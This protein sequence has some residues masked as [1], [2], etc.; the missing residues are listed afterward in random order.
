MVETT[1]MSAT[2]VAAEHATESHAPYLKVWAGLAV[3]TLVEYYY[4]SI[5]KSHFLIL[6]LGLLLLAVVKAGMV[7][8][9]FMH[10]KFEGNW[11]YIAIV[12]AMI[13][14]T[15]IVLALSPDMV[16]KPETEENPGEENARV[17]PAADLPRTILAVRA[18]TSDPGVGARAV[19]RWCLNQTL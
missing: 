12:P 17:A 1:K 4:A 7:G 10:L 14:A 15:I 9:Y 13:L 5:F 8:W 19:R 6:L 16:L 11:V 2:E 18:D 3:L